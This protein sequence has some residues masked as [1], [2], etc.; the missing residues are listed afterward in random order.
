M[1][2]PAPGGREGEKGVVGGGVESRRD[3][4]H[5]YLYTVLILFR[6]NRI[7]NVEPET[8][9]FII[10]LLKKKF[11]QVDETCTGTTPFTECLLS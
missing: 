4:N 1:T 11:T 9:D 7:Q 2:T 3:K 8:E 10:G 6:R 5:L